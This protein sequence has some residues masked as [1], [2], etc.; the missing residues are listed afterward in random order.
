M[1]EPHR[2]RQEYKR[3]LKVFL[4]H[5]SEDKVIT[6]AL[7]QR[8]KKTGF[9][10]WV[11]AK[12]LGAGELWEQSICDAL[13]KTD[14]VVVCLSQAFSKNDRYVQTELN[15]AIKI[16][17]KQYTGANFLVPYK[18]EEC[19]IPE[20]LRHFHIVNDFEEEGFELL[21]EALNIRAKELDILEEEVYEGFLLDKDLFRFYRKIFDRPAF[22]GPFSWQTDPKPFKRGMELTLKAI[23]TGILKDKTGTTLIEDM[24]TRGDIRSETLRITME[25]IAARLK[26]ICNLVASPEEPGLTGQGNVDEERD[27]IIKKLNEI[28]ITI[29]IPPMT[30]PT[31]IK[32]NTYSWE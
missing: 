20:S 1:R 31:E 14:V 4:C 18:L 32:D 11:D 22:R 8:L 2:L 29:G 12:S 16:A 15:Y 7:F 3:P 6:Q 26:K 17:N 9:Q 23:N 24:P 27:E 25:E 13:D 5:S 28:W 10:P 21:V 30:I 19:G